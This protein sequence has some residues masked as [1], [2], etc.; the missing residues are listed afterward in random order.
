VSVVKGDGRYADVDDGEG[1]GTSV[2][3]VARREIV[4]EIRREER[5]VEM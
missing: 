1:R 5:N 4:G 3:Y 2:W